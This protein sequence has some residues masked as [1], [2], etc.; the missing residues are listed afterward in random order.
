MIK[1]HFKEYSQEMDRTQVDLSKLVGSRLS[2][3]LYV[4]AQQNLVTQCH[5]VYI[6]IPNENGKRGLLL[7]ERKQEPAKGVLWP[8]GGRILRG[9]FT[10]DS[11][12]KKAKEECGLDLEDITY[13]GVSRVSWG[14]DALNQGKGSDAFGFNYF[15][16]GIGEI[17]LNDLHQKPTIITPSQY[18]EEFRSNLHPYMRE[19]MDEAIEKVKPWWRRMWNSLINQSIF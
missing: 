15:A 14:G 12:R 18:T 19:F 9:M 11:L 10:E 6:G 2:D 1:N 5:D 7:V 3:E 13:L 16:R 4:Q 17:N 8:I